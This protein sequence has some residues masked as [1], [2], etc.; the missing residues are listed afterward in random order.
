M[1]I[2]TITPM[3]QVQ[4]MPLCPDPVEVDML[5]PAEVV[6]DEVVPVEVVP[7]EVVVVPS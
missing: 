3:I 7:V 5:R 1:I 2:N 4:F 6:P